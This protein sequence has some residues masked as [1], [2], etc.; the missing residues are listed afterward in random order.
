MTEKGHGGKRDGAGRKGDPLKDLELGAKTA[1]A[2]LDRLGSRRRGPDKGHIKQLQK[3]YDECHDA[4]IK[5]YIIFRMREWAYGKAVQTLKV[6]NPTGKNGQ[7]I[8]FEVD[9][10]SAR[11]KL[12][13]DLLS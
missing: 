11:A 9:V 4:R 5:T 3:L 7:P 12:A 6:A 10:I 2:L 8:P 13:A 1:Q